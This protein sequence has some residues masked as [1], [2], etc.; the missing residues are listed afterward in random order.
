MLKT[1][2]LSLFF[3]FKKCN[4][5]HLRYITS[6]VIISVTKLISV[7]VRREKMSDWEEKYNELFKQFMDMTIK[8]AYLETEVDRLKKELKFANEKLSRAGK[9][10]NTELHEDIKFYLKEKHSI[11]QIA[12]ELNC[13]PTT[14][15]KVKKQLSNDLV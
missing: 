11:R 8:N 10:V 7:T 2:L 1:G 3:Y 14:V 6:Y 9:N 13:S 4:T 12:Q 15:Q 5:Y